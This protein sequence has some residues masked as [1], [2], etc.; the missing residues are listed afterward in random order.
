[1]II[2]RRLAKLEAALP[3]RDAVLHWLAEAQQFPSLVDHARS[4][5]DLPVEAAPLS[6]IGARVEASVHEAHK[7]QPRDVIQTAARRAVGDAVFLFCLVVILNGQA[8][9]VA[10]VE[11][12]RVS[13]TFFWMGALLG[14]PHEPPTSDEDAGERRAA[15]RLWRG[16]V[17][18]L[19]GDARVETAARVSLERRYLA[20]HDVLFA[21][22]ATAWAE[23]VDMVERLGGLAE[24][25]Q[26]GNPAKIG[27]RKPAGSGSSD[28]FDARVGALASRLADDARVRAYEVLGD[29]ARAVSIIERRLRS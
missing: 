26:P 15:W 18:R 3:P 16:V 6:V 28:S 27:R 20:G 14:G 10:R 21:D 8:L 23:H 5:V 7:G 12:L 11:G 29:R 25:I 24:V 2:E 4:I 19:M 22:V 17:D 9:D 1:V 13:A